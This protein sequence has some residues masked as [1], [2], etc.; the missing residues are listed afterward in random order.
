[1]SSLYLLRHANAA[2]PEPGKTDRDRHLNDRGIQACQAIMSNIQDDEI[3]PDIILC[4]TATRTRETLD[5]IKNAWDASIPVEYVDSI[6]EAHPDEIRKAIA[7]HTS[8]NKAIMVIG[9][10]PGLQML[11]LDL[12]DNQNG[13]AYRETSTNFPAGALAKLTVHPELW[14]DVEPG[15]F[16][17]LKLMTV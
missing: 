17:Y 13:R 11:A 5:Q 12:S 3:R 6:Y 10:N 4:S 15:K 1:M 8:N 2:V 9:H 7:A 14:E 16:T